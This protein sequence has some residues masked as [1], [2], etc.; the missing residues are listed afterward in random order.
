MDK[1]CRKT[2]ANKIDFHISLTFCFLALSTPDYT[3]AD[4]VEIDKVAWLK[5]IL[6]L[7]ST[8]SVEIGT[9]DSAG[10]PEHD[11][12]AKGLGLIVRDK[13]RLTNGM[14]FFRRHAPSLAK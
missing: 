5:N 14:Q 4:S 12:A 13:P 8:V 11:S 9:N 6:L 3:Y 7:F 2:D 10:K 1:L